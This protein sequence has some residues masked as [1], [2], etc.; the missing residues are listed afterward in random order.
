[1]ANIIRTDSK[2]KN[3][4]ALVKLLDEELAIRDGDDHAFYTQF[5]SLENIKYVVLIYENK[6]PIGCGALKEFSKE[7]VEVKRM[8][9]NPDNRGHNLAS[10]IIKELEK[11]TF[12]LGFQKCVLETG[13]NQPEAIRLYK[14]NNFQ[15][16]EN[17]GPYSGVKT[18]ICFEKILNQFL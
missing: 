7:A 13:Y 8:Y 14:K 2:N 1:M 10:H 16:I 9:V 4:Q 6:I 3:F 11:W 18:S 15:I 17:Y 5:N 12:E